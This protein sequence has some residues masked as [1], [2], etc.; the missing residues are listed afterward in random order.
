MAG[1]HTAFIPLKWAWQGPGSYVCTVVISIIVPL[2]TRFPSALY[3]DK[4]TLPGR[5]VPKKPESG[6]AV[7]EAV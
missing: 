5:K 3:N 1:T 6:D 4:E 7:I 2:S